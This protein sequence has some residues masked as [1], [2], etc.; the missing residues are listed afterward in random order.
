MKRYFRLLSLFLCVLCAA[1][2]LFDADFAVTAQLVST[3]NET[4]YV[5]PGG[6]LVGLRLRTR[7]VTV[8]GTTPFETDAGT[9]DPAAAAGIKKGDVLLKMDGKTVSSNEALT[10]LIESSAGRPLET[11][12]ER[13]GETLTLTLTPQKTAGTGLY[14]GGLWVRDSAAGIGT[15]TFSD[16][17]SGRIATLGHG[18]FDVDTGGAIE[19][20][21]GE[22]RTATVV[23]I[24]KG[25]AGVAGEIGGRIGDTQLGTVDRNDDRG[26]YGDLWTVT[27]ADGTVPVATRSEV[28]TGA[29]QVICTVT[30]GEKR[31][32]DVEITRLRSGDGEKSLTLKV[33]DAALLALTGGIVQGMSGSPV[34]QDGKLVGAV[35]H[36]FVN[37]PKCGYAIY[38]EDM[39]E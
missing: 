12:V 10:K 26:V 23:G 4:R 11:V 35:T 7:G 27:D 8:V 34:M 39:L 37:D 25:V 28:H 21:D 30:E 3:K 32:Y 19:V 1:G 29:A 33:T 16:P 38:A 14:R 22:I 36:V 6:D 13:G 31:S 18:I 9:A 20:A 5:Y 17:V 15:L 2:F 24:T